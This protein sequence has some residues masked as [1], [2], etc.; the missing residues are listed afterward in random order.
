MGLLDKIEN[1]MHGNKGQATHGQGEQPLYSSS[2][3]QGIEHQ[4]NLQNPNSGIGGQGVSGQGMTGSGGSRSHDLRHPVQ[5]ATGHAGQD[6]YSQVGTYGSGSHN[7]DH[8]NDGYGETGRQKTHAHNP[9]DPYS[10]SGQKA[11]YNDSDRANAQNHSSHGSGGHGLGRSHHNN[12]TSSSDNYGSGGRSSIENHNAIPT[13]GGEKVGG[14]GNDH[15]S[16]HHYG[17]DAALAGGAGAIGAGEYERRN[18]QSSGHHGPGSHNQSSEQYG[19]QGLSSSGHQGGA[20]GGQTGRSSYDNDTSNS[21]KSGIAAKLGL[22]HSSNKEHGP[23]HSTSGGMHDTSSSAMP[24]EKKLGGAY[25]AGYR[26]A[27]AHA[28]AEQQRR[29]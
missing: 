12:N 20:Y 18:Q 13:A 10:A 16:Q 9:V 14:L 5:S 21:G 23:D 15:Q 2:E 29:L 11:I 25:E 26:D 6:Q 8:N 17:R 4:A 27:M 28:Q 7:T 22:G 24:T 3:R 1:K 19:G